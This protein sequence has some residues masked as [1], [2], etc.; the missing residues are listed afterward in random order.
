MHYSINIT[1][2]FWATI[3]KQTTTFP[4]NTQLIQWKRCFL[5][6]LFKIRSVFDAYRR[7]CNEKDANAKPGVLF[8][9]RGHSSEFRR[10]LANT[11]TL[12]PG[13]AEPTWAVDSC[14]RCD[15][16]PVSR[17]RAAVGGRLLRLPAAAQRS[18]RAVEAD[19]AGCA[20]QELHAGGESKD[21][22][23]GGR[24]M[25]GWRGWEMTG[26]GP[27]HR[28]TAMMIRSVNVE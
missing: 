14:L 24:L 28:I 8:R 11:A 22:P 20:V 17:S 7:R 6:D 13:R 16:A 12:P 23:S 4:I 2:E 9:N 26:A 18:Q 15:E 5:K 1:N 3:V 21:A 27:E 19:A 25:W 10:S